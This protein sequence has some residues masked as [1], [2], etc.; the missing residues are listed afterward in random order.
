MVAH[1]EKLCIDRCWKVVSG[2]SIG[3]PP[4]IEDLK[5]HLSNYGQT[6]GGGATL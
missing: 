1:R 5:T 6:V 3:K 2:L 4:K